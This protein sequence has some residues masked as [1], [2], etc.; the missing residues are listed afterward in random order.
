MNNKYLINEHNNLRKKFN[1]KK[2]LSQVQLWLDNL[3]HIASTFFLFI[4]M[5]YNYF[6][7]H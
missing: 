7:R 3:R 4:K 2:L 5:K 6:V 1:K